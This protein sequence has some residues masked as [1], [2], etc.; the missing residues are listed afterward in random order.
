MQGINNLL[1]VVILVLLGSPSWAQPVIADGKEWLQPRDFRLLSWNDVNAVC[2][3]GTCTGTLTGTGGSIDVTGYTW[4]TQAEVAELFNSYGVNPPLTSP[5]TSS[6]SEVNSTWA[7]AFQEDFQRTDSSRVVGW[8]SSDTGDVG[9]YSYIQDRGPD[10]AD[11]ASP[12]NVQPKENSFIT[13]GVWLYRLP[14][15]PPPAPSAAEPIPTLSVYGLVLTMLGLF[16]V[17]ARRLSSRKGRKG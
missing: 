10:E 3:A 13:I 4:A 2:P 9:H 5:F 12:Y 11:L 7:P 16:T 14:P 6:S 15:P 8:S 1:A 17:A